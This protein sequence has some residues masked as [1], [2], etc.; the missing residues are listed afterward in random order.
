MQSETKSKYSKMRKYIYL[1]IAYLIL[2]F[3]NQALSA[4]WEKLF[5]MSGADSFRDV[6]ELANGDFIAI[7]YTDNLNSNDTDALVMRFNSN[8][9]QLWKYT[10]NSTSNNEDGFYRGLPTSDGGFILCGFSISNSGQDNALFIKLSSSGNLQWMQDWGGSGY[11]RAKDII[12]IPGEKFIAVG[13]TSSSPAQSFDM[14]ILKL[15][16]NGNILWDEVHGDTT[17][18]EANTVKLLDDG[19]FLIG[20]LGDNDYNIIRTDSDG[21]EIWSEHLGTSG[22]DVI[23][24]LV[25]AHGGNGFMLAGT[26][27]GA[28]AGAEDAYLVKTDTNGVVQW[29]KFY[30]GPLNDGFQKINKTADG[31]YVGS[32]TTRTGPWPDPN[33]WIFKIDASGNMLW[34]KYYGGDE[35]DHGYSASETSDGGFIVSGHSRSFALNNPLPDAFLIKTDANGNVQNRLIYTTVSNLISP[36]D[37][38]C[39]TSNVQI[40][41][42]L[43]NYSDTTVPNIPVTVEITGPVNQTITSTYSSSVPRNGVVTHTFNQTVD[44]SAAGTYNFYCYTGNRH[45]VYP[46]HNDRN[47][48]IVITTSRA[49]S[50]VITNNSRCGPGQ[51]TLSATSSNTVRWYDDD[52]NGTLLHTG[53][54][55]TTSYLIA[56]SVYYVQAGTACPSAII[57]VIADVTAGIAAPVVSDAWRCG[58]GSVAFTASSPYPVYWYESVTSLVPVDTGYSFNTPSISSNHPYYVASEDSN[59]T[60]VRVLVNAVVQPVP[61]E[62]ITTDGTRCGEGVLLLS[63]SAS[64]SVQWFDASTGGNFLGSGSI[65]TSPF[66]SGTSIY[67]ARSYNGYCFSNGISANAIIHPFP[68]I[69]LGPDTV[70]T[71]QSNYILDAGAGYSTYLWSTSDVTQ[72]ITVNMNG[73]Y[74]VTVSDSNSCLDTACVYVEFSTGVNEKYTNHINLF[75]DPSSGFIAIEFPVKNT[76]VK[77]YVFDRTGKL[78]FNDQ[79]SSSIEYID[80]SFLTRGL[81]LGYISD[82]EEIYSRKFVID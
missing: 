78:V 1:T 21:D 48:S 46:D 79:L 52:T 11:E 80:L 55:F 57:P 7:G 24:S 9:D 23:K 36:I 38:T 62:P 59:C 6:H 44:L 77:F 8:G 61:V 28:G 54:T 49:S 18:E 82:G 45:D 13:Y 12:E 27:T 17:Y 4:T 35:H 5:S 66:I 19:G 20:G 60:S 3:S 22:I 58:S 56:D 51:V 76:P 70:Y 50:P 63:A 37:A 31:G 69:N 72:T 14:F 40:V 39:G 75:P 71:S 30:G 42:E 41:V 26:T 29:S 74:C 64:D 25:I 81:Y 33:V 65:F 47:E 2:Q 16:D 53:L 34:Q 73:I 15:D 68:V 67:Y 32:G 43:I 10:F